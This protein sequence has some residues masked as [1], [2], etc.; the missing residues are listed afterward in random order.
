MFE[1]EA[2][3]PCFIAYGHGYAVSDAKR[4]LVT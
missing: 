2:W 1:D 3:V 4:Y